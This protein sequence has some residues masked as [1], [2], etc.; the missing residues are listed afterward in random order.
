MFWIK[1]ICF[2]S[3]DISLNNSIVKGRTTGDEVISNEAPTTTNGNAFFVYD[4]K[5]KSV[6]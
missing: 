3:Q 2:W 6:P 5:Y 1:S 4:K